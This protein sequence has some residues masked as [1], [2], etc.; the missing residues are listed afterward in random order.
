MTINRRHLFSLG[1]AGAVLAATGQPASADQG[2]DDEALVRSL[3]GFRSGYANVNGIRMHYVAGGRGRPL[4]LVP[5]W[6]QTWWEF[7]KIMPALA[8]RYRVIAVD[9]RGQGG[10]DKP[11]GGYDKKTMARDIHELVRHLGYSTVDIAGH[12]IGAMVAFSFAV[13]HPDSTRTVTIMDV[14]HPDENLFKIPMLAPPGQPVNVWWFAFNQV[15]GLPEQLL[16]GRFRPLVDWLFDTLLVNPA[17]VGD[18]DRAVYARAYSRPDAIRA[19]NAW[20]QA[21]YQDIEDQTAYRKV[22]APMLGL[23]AEYNDTLAEVLP[24]K[25]TDVRLAK[26]AGSGHFLPE[27]QPDAVV[28]ALTDFLG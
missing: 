17:S 8:A 15:R 22:T 21:F 7:R 16:A 2:P 28:K 26:I 13:N 14:A 4:V 10:S 3:P 5:G 27:E 1:A 25:G 6:P 19:G 12:D 11:A 18:R 23:A 20:Y 9:L 24:G